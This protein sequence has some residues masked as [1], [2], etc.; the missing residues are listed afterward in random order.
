MGRTESL[1]EVDWASV[2]LPDAWPD[3]LNLGSPLTWLQLYRRSRKAGSQKV[4]LPE[5]LIGADRIP[6]YILLE[7]HGLPN[8]NYSNS[9]A[10]GYARSFDHVMLGTLSR[11]RQRIAKALT[12]ARTVLDVGC[13]GGRMAQALQQAGVAE[14]RGIDPSPYLLQVAA[15]S[16]PGA[17]FQQGL[18]EALEQPDTSVDG[19]TACFVLHEMPPPRVDEALAEF[20]RVLRPGGRF[21]LIE[22]SRVQ[23]TWTATRLLRRYG[24][25][26]LYFRWMAGLVREPFLEAWHRRDIVA[27][28]Q[29]AGFVVES[30]TEGCPL[31]EIVALKPA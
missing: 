16:V 25:K 6:E 18:A 3:A 15:Q 29:A 22:P 1:T 31:R 27:S 21:G 11:A 13:G 23:W 19:L 2:Q 28:L 30:D 9:V 5:G 7:F 20:F 10:R 12:P 14:V 26:G 24:W 17:H 8:G 4:R